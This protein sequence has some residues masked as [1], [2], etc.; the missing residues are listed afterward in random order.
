MSFFLHAE[1]KPNSEHLLIDKEKTAPSI[2]SQTPDDTAP[3]STGDVEQFE[4]TRDHIERLVSDMGDA[5]DVIRV[6]TQNGSPHQEVEEVSYSESE[7]YNATAPNIN[8]SELNS[9][10]LEVNESLPEGNVKSD[11]VADAELLR[12]QEDKPAAPTAGIDDYLEYRADDSDRVYAVRNSAQG[13][14]VTEEDRDPD[15]LF[16][17]SSVQRNFTDKVVTVD[18]RQATVESEIPSQLGD[19]AAEEVR[20]KIIPF[21]FFFLSMATDPEARVR[22]PALPE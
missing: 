19:Q 3:D 11:G 20:D 6:S 5:V 21:M 15:Q 16:D 4:Q 13:E 17:A 2:P 8:T 22:F 1:D 12:G 10:V 9:N 7:K 14:H 18:S